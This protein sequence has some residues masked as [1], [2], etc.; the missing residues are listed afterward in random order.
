MDCKDC[1]VYEDREGCEGK[2]WYDMSMIQFCRQQMIFLLVHIGE[3]EE[4]KW[5]QDPLGGS[6]DIEPGKK[7][8]QTKPPFEN[9]SCIKAE[10]E[11]RLKKIDKTQGL[12]LKK[13]GLMLEAYYGWDK[14]ESSLANQYDLSEREVRKRIRRALNYI[15]GKKRRDRGYAEFVIHS[16]R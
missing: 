16:R 14:T 5:P 11:V 9:L 8:K 1:K 4:G 3:L 7:P 10:V 12:G 13:D 15:T 2:Y 6:Y